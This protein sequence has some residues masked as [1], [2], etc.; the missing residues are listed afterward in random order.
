MRAV[1]RIG[2][3][4]GAAEEL[5]LTP[6]ALSRRVSSVETWLGTSLFE[7][8]GRGMRLS[9]NGQI[10]MARIEDG[11]TLIEAAADPWRS[12]RGPDVV[13]LSVVPSFARFW[14]FDHF[15]A[16]EIGEQGAQRIRI[17]LST[18][19]KL[20]DIEAGEADIAIRFGRGNWRGVSA[21]LLV[22]EWLVPIANRELAL[23]LG[24]DPKPAQILSLPM[25]HD[26]DAAGWRAWMVGQ[27]VQGYRPRP[28]DKRFDEYDL[29]L[30]AA[31]GGLGVALG[32][33]PIAGQ[34]IKAAGLAVLSKQGAQ[35]PGGYY[36][37]TRNNE[38]RPSI[39]ALAGRIEKALRSFA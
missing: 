1:A 10:F 25:I 32:R 3:L 17:E 11:F 16:L 31:R 2:S 15:N 22:R 39:I 35:N 38:L 14:L 27:G 28:Q 9:A 30:A 24:N 4:S 26:S 34:A 37:V 12:R 6:G 23:A 19:Y 18:D 36:L 33:M 5:G 21:R 29:V 13:R 20:A 7:R 8:H